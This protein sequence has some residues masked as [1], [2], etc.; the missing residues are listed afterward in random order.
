MSRGLG[1]LQR[2]ILEALA[3]YGEEAG[4]IQLVYRVAGV[5][6]STR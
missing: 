3:D 6:D 1:K 2:T 4:L 5:T